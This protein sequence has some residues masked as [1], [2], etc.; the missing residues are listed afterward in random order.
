MRLFVAVWIDEPLR[1]ALAALPLPGATGRIRRTDPSQYH[2]TLRFLGEVPPDEADR[3]A[4]TMAAHVGSVAPFP[5]R[6]VDVGT[7]DRSRGGVVVARIEP[8]EGWRSLHGAVE[9][10]L[11]EHGFAPERRPFVPHVTLARVKGGRIARPRSPSPEATKPIGEGFVSE[12]ALVKSELRPDGPVYRDL[13]RFPL[14][15]GG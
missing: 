3:L 12:A 5:Y 14:A 1:A 9:R 8:S 11:S 2:V 4:R 6:I 15:G 7:F 10:A 13:A